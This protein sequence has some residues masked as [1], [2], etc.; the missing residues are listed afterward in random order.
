MIGQV[1]PRQ[2]LQAARGAK[3]GDILK[4]CLKSCD[5]CRKKNPSKFMLKTSVNNCS[6]VIYKFMRQT[7]ES[8][9][10]YVK[11]NEM[12]FVCYETVLTYLC[13]GKALKN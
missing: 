3:M 9:F 8:I 2:G 13:E 5:R 4:K 12:V 6:L 1:V 11:N 10:L 7:M